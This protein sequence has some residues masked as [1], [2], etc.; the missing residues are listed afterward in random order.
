MS[1]W[2][3]FWQLLMRMFEHVWTCEEVFGI[4]E[5]LCGPDWYWSWF[6][7]FCVGLAY[8]EMCSSTEFGAGDLRKWVEI[9]EEDE[10]TSANWIKSEVPEGL[11]CGRYESAVVWLGHHRLSPWGVGG[12]CWIWRFEAWQRVGCDGSWSLEVKSERILKVMESDSQT[13]P[14]HS[15]SE[16]L[17]R[18]FSLMDSPMI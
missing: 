9:L 2:C 6:D 1:L 3:A 13:M 7:L 12:R 15:D 8:L 14:N 11:V 4:R 17:D 16:K 18:F 5:F 10:M